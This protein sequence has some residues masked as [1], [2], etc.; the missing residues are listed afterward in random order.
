ML[1]WIFA[2]V[3]AIVFAY[4]AIFWFA[5]WKWGLA[6]LVLTWLARGYVFAGVALLVMYIMTQRLRGITDSLPM[7][8]IGAPMPMKP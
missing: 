4:I 2:V 7:R 8:T 5:G 6:A 1:A 3:A